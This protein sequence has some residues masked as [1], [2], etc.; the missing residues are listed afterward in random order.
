MKIANTGTDFVG[1]LAQDEVGNVY[2][3]SGG[4]IA[5]ITPGWIVGTYTKES[6]R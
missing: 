2:A 5:R 6:P 3:C 1:G 4:A